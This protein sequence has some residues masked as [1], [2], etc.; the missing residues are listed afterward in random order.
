[1]ISIGI[2]GKHGI[3]TEEL[4]SIASCEDFKF[5][6]KDFSEEAFMRV[7]QQLFREIFPSTE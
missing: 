5:D 7:E 4:I 1:M 3:S 6:I 2:E